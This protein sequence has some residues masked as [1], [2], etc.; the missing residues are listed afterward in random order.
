MNFTPELCIYS[1]RRGFK[2]NNYYLINTGSVWN[3]VIV[4]ALIVIFGAIRF[5]NPHSGTWM[6]WA[7]AVLGAWMAISPWI[8]GYDFNDGR[9]WNS[10][11]VGLVVLVL[12]IWSAVA[13]RSETPAT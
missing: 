1:S 8:Y 3:S 2:N 13:T 10:L 12:G 7:N 11:I 6:S 9:M 4:G 5:F